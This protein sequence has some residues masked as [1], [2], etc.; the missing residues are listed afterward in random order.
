M[1]HMHGML[2]QDEILYICVLIVRIT[3]LIHMHKT[4]EELN[5]H[6]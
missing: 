6:A 2:L 3:W 5:V 1:D 4:Q